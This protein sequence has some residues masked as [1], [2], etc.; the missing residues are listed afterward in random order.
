MMATGR[1]WPR[2]CAFSMDCRWRSSLAARVPVLSPAQLL[3]RLKDRFR[4]LAGARGAAARQATLRAAIDWSWDLLAQW[5]Q[6]A[7]AQCSIFDGGFTLEAAEAVLDLSAWP[8]APP[9]MDVVQALSDKSLLRTWVR[10][11]H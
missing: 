6:A 2:W 1:R 11:E 3:A 7:F 5:E 9:A 8:E 10:A 4:L